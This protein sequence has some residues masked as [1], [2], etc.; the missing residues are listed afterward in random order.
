M[1]A[2]Q[3]TW[4]N[5]VESCELSLY[6]AD[7]E[8]NILTDKFRPTQS[9]ITTEMGSLS[10]SAL[11]PSQYRPI[12]PYTSSEPEPTAS[13]EAHASGRAPVIQ[14]A[15]PM[16]YTDPPR[17]LGQSQ[18]PSD[19]SRQISQGKESRSS[20]P[21]DTRPSGSEQSRQEGSS[22]KETK[23]KNPGRSPN[24][25]EP[26][27]RRDTGAPQLK[28][29]KSIAESLGLNPEDPAPPAPGRLPQPKAPPKDFG[30]APP[31]PNKDGRRG[32]RR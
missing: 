15:P 21:K 10:V 7:R 16:S 18:A 13:D 4:L 9:T 30:P 25:P 14:R 12:A 8:D 28:K 23:R 1:R 24:Q 11:A 19:S 29:K 32:G 17:G 27:K 2:R 20:A 26:T 31:P 6:R 22:R 5:V 3:Q